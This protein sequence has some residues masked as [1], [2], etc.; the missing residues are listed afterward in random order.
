[1]PLPPAST[2][3][4]LNMFGISFGLVGLAGAWRTAA[5]ED[6]T[7]V[8]IGDALLV[9]TAAA[10]L[11][12]LLVYLRYVLSV[13]GAF[14]ADLLD[15]VGA[16]FASLAVI[17]P[18][19][20]AAQGIV[21]HAFTAG[22]IVVDVFLALTF[23]LGAWF[24]GQWMYGT[25]DFDRLHPGYFLPTAAGGLIAS[26]SASAAGQQRLAEVMFG[27]GVVCWLI[28]GSMILARLF[29]RPPLPGPLVPT[30]A[31][32]VA[33]PAVASLAYYA[34]NGNQIDLVAAMLAGY[35]LVM[36]FAQIRLLPR[37]VRL[38]F[39]P[40]TWAFTFSYAA[41]ASSALHWIGISAPAGERV[42]AYLL[43]AAI[44]LLI[45]GIGAR[46]LVAL[47]RRQLLPHPPTA[48]PA[49]A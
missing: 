20:L 27:F 46:T 4:P 18:M 40:S 48:Q 38:Q 15:T 31:I 32:E 5:L 47:A 14:V 44:T 23:L 13:K 37:Y 24:T 25:L 41:V 36:A 7:A 49:A 1:M 11:V 6:L 42:Y 28:L 17:V 22:R 10:W 26:A 16:P 45:G 2:R 33:P 12:T 29:F 43:L 39:A 34:I 9:L 35:G 30:M 8:W 3:I 19:T 21:P